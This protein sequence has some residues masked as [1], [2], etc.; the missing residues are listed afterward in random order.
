V[1]ARRQQVLARRKPGSNNQ[2]RA[3]VLVRKIHRRIE[4]Q[5][6]QFH[7]EEAK[8]LVAVHGAIAVENLRIDNMV[9]RPAPRPAGQA[10]PCPEQKSQRK[11][12]RA[13]RIGE[14]APPHYLPN[15]ASAKSGLNKSISDAGWGTF[16]MILNYKAES[17]GVLFVKV[18]AHGTSQLCSG[19]GKEVPKTL[20]ERWHI[21]PHCGLSLQRDHNS[22]R[23]I[24]QRA[25][26]GLGEPVLTA[27]G[28]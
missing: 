20:A 6:H 15:G 8:K 12:R 7:H 24:Y 1:L 3:R 13:E 17:A 4:R 25:F 21:C 9:K 16:L 26:G 22:A 2:H 5:R 23:L 18:S 28:P 10:D 19:C 14:A 11:I 27:S